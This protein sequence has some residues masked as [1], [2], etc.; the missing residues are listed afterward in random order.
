M[1][2]KRSLVIALLMVALVLAACSSSK[3]KSTATGTSTPGSTAA[4]ALTASF[5]GVTADSI[6]IGIVIIDYNTIKDFVDFTRGDQQKIAQSFVDDINAKGGVLGRKIVPVYKTYKPIG[7]QDTLAICTSL[8]QDEKVFAVLGVFIDPSGDSQLCLTRDHQTIHIGHELKQEWIAQ[9]P[10][11]LLLTPD[12]SAERRAQVVFSLLKQ[13]KTLDGK[14]V[15]ILADPDTKTAAETVIKPGLVGLG[16]QL[17]STAVIN[18]GGSTDTSQAQAQIDSF[19][20]KWKGEGVN[21]LFMA[22]LNVSAKQFVEK[23]KKKFPAMVLVTD[24]PSGVHS[25]AQDEVKAKKNPNPYEGIITAEGLTD[26]EKWQEPV[27]QACAAVWEAASGTKIVGP[28]DLKPGPDGKRAEIYIAVQD[29]CGELKMFKIIAE[30][31][32]PNLTND[33]WMSTVN[34]FGSINGLVTTSIA[35]LKTGKY[36]ADDAFR[37]EAFDSSLPPTGDWK[38]LTPLADVTK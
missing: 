15:A 13:N 27:Q 5:R 4:P 26:V 37:L 6:K 28:A 10:G 12:I 36:D 21:A 18:V 16:L 32:G 19:L 20:E 34:S 9:A 2:R 1:A 7:N 35:S 30:K 3:P 24:A 31:V 22:G 11:G 23:I 29:F 14:K 33:T 17:G 38:A 25:A 8:T